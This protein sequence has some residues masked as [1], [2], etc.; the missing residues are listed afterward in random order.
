ML[1]RFGKELSGPWTLRRQFPQLNMVVGTSC[2]GT[3][4][5]GGLFWAPGNMKK[6]DKVDV[7]MKNMQISAPNLSLGLP[8][9]QWLKAYIK[10]S[11]TVPR[12]YRNQDPRVAR[13]EPSPQSYWES[14]VGIQSQCLCSETL[15]FGPA[16]T[17]CNGRM[18]QNPMK[19]FSVTQTRMHGVELNFFN[20]RT[21][22]KANVYDCS[23]QHQP[24][25]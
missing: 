10:I 16:E 2:C 17:I 5:T 1:V 24:E 22:V 7:L 23:A 9:R 25:M 3:S 19:G 20:Y 18:D 14:V 12:G 15:Q 21:Q 4:V 11:L 13:T 6:E 8:K